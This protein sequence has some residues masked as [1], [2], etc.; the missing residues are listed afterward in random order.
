[1]SENINTYP[2]DLQRFG[3]LSQVELDNNLMSDAAFE[4]NLRVFRSSPRMFRAQ[5]HRGHELK[6]WWTR[7]V[8]FPQEA[9]EIAKSKSKTKE[10]LIDRGV[11]VPEIAGLWTF[12]QA[13]EAV[14]QASEGGPWTV[15]PDI[16]SGGVGVSKNVTNAEEA[17]VAVRKI[18]TSESLDRQGNRH[19]LVERYL[20]GPQIRVLVV[21]GEVVGAL[22]VSP[23]HVTG[24]G[25][26]TIREL[27][28]D[29][30]AKLAVNPRRVHDRVVPGPR[31]LQETYG[32]DVNTVLD[33]GAGIQIRRDHS[34]KNG[35]FTMDITDELSQTVRRAAIDAVA[36]VP[37]LFVGGVDMIVRPGFGRV[38]NSVVGVLEINSSPGIGSHHFP[39]HGTGRNVADKIIRV[40]MDEEGLTNE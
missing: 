15:K 5:D 38:A 36:A 29:A 21:D 22:Y 30:T 6:V 23:P 7:R 16:G 9:R 26:S 27:A 4:Q 25:V 39:T 14:R 13:E 28:A 32:Y 17:E 3:V 12:D 34:M 35:A 37:N 33:R 11:K 20:P 19:I 24:D 10:R 2:H 40:Y 31:F 18:L 1:L 8:P